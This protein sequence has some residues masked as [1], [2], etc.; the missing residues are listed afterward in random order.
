V[1]EDVRW[2]EV[3]VQDAFLYQLHEAFQDVADVL[4]GFRDC[5]FLLVEEFLQVAASTVLLDQVEMVVGL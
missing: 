3:A 1:E 5:E 2:G 4:E